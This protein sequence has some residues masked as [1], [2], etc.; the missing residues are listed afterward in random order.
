[1]KESETQ[2]N[3]V[4]VNEK[5]SQILE[6]NDVLNDMIEDFVLKQEILNLN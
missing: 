5:Y 6:N 4:L 3:L 1:M 2:T